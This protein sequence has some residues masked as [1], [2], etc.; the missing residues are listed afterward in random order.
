MKLKTLAI[1]ATMSLSA[2]SAQWVPLY[3]PEVTDAQ[4]FYDR[5]TLAGRDTKAGGGVDV[6]ILTVLK[7]ADPEG[8]I[9]IVQRKAY[10]CNPA[11]TGGRFINVTVETSRY[12]AKNQRNLLEP[13]IKS[14]KNTPFEDS[15]RNPVDRSAV[16]TLCSSVTGQLHEHLNGSSR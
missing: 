10:Y 4:Y 16:G 7:S 8:T 11:K 5:D 1:L 2:H 13:S 9:E 12:G 3:V 15:T 14:D 6:R